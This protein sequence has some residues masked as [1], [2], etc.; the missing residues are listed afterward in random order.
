MSALDRLLERI[1]DPRDASKPRPLVTLEEFF[2]DND[3]SESLGSYARDR[4]VPSDFYNALVELRAVAGFHE[5]FVEILPE[6][7]H[8]GWPRSETVWIVSDFDRHELPRN[9]TR[10]FWD[11]FLPSD[12]LSYPRIGGVSLET[13][14]VP[15][16]AFVQGFAYYYYNS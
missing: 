13:L 6:L 16:G 2:T 7:S 5:I 12:W 8:S 4:F 3:D 11:G 10:T 9:L 15:E 1:G 14:A